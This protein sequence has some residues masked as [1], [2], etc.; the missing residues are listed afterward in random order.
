MSGG[1]KPIDNH[2]TNFVLFCNPNAC[3]YEFINYQ[4]EWL[5]YYTQTLGLNVIIFNYRG[6]GRSSMSNSLNKLQGFF[7]VMDPKHVMRDGE[8]VLEYAREKFIQQVDG[9]IQVKVIVHGESMG[10]MVASY[11]AMKSA[12]NKQIPVDFAF[13]N[14]T[15]SSLD[16][17]AYWSA[18]ITSLRNKVGQYNGS[19]SSS[20]SVCLVDRSSF[21]QYLGK[22]VSL[23]F[24]FVTQWKDESW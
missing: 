11:V 19:D 8:I 10:G 9:S 13:I 24:R 17:V 4:S 6:Y 7:G 14:R 18:G 21:S 12:I 5:K 2:S 20:R 22:F 1:R 16:S 15:F 3:F 23:V